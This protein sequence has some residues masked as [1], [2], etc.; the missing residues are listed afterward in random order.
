MN[1]HMKE[2][3]IE[4]QLEHVYQPL[5]NLENWNILGY[6]ALIRVANGSIENVESLFRKAREEGY[7]YEF[8]TASIKNAVSHFPFSQLNKKL[9]FLNIYPSTILHGRFRCFL[10]E[11]TSKFPETSGQIVFELNE[12]KEEDEIWEVAELKEKIQMIKSYGFYIA[13]DDVGR[14][15]ST[16]QKI[17]EFQPSYIKLDRYFAKDLAIN[18]EKQQIVTLLANYCRR[19]MVLI[20]EGIETEVDLAQ[21]KLLRVPAAQGYLL[22]KPEKFL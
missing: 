13:I 8:D 15:A 20:L 2:W 17:I 9:L 16:L 5:W 11:L 14:G 1:F 18:E 6:E 19:K 3:G 10:D 21:A 22:G 4:E 12:T 7:L